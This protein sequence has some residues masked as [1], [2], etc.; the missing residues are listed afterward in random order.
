MAQ[1]NES[2]EELERII[3]ERKAGTSPEEGR[4]HDY[5]N[6]ATHELVWGILENIGCQP[7]RGEDRYVIE[8]AYQGKTFW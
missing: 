7:K 1:L 8:F 4:E 2:R 6:E 3:E 5:S